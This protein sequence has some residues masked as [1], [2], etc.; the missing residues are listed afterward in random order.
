MTLLM[1]LD[2]RGLPSPNPTL[3]PSQGV[4]LVPVSQVAFIQILLSYALSASL[5]TFTCF[6]FVF[7]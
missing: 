1:V 6:I 2:V 5:L 7:E 3:H 4:D